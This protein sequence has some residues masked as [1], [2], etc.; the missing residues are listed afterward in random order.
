MIK[1][2]KT[3]YENGIV[4]CT[5]IDVK[6]EEDDGGHCF[7]FNEKDIDEVMSVL[8]KLKTAKPE[9]YIQSKEE[10]LE[11]QKEKLFE[12]KWYVKFYR[13]IENFSLSC[14]PFDWGF[15]VEP[16]TFRVVSGVK[17]GPFTITF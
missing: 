12:S 16:F 13:L 11:I 15:G 5:L 9:I 4:L 3:Q 6:S 8:N 1:F 7:D 14:S 2:E 17:A 10:K